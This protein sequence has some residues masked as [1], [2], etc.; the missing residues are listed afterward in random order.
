[1]LSQVEM[2]E[3]AKSRPAGVIIL[4]G[5]HGT[6]ALA[7]S[8]G[9]Q[10]VPVWLVSADTPLPR[11][12]R[13]ADRQMTWPGSDDDGAVAFLL[14]LAE[15]QGFDGFLLIPGGDPEVRL[16]SQSIDQLSRLRRDLSCVSHASQRTPESN[17]EPPKCRPD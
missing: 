13:Y 5:A 15:T 8:L 6:L 11:F 17:R 14:K 2:R 16:V 3:Y 10:K 7:R 1:M 9:A 4:G 12:S